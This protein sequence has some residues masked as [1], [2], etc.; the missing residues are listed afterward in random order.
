MIKYCI[1]IPCLFAGLLPA[2][3][4]AGCQSA[5]ASLVFEE[6]SVKAVDLNNARIA[7]P[8]NNPG[9]VSYSVITL[10]SLVMRAYNVRWYQ[11]EGPNH[12]DTGH[13]EIAAKIPEGVP[14]EQTPAMLFNLLAARFNLRTPL[15]IAH[16]NGLFPRGG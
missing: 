3:I 13:Y 10:R 2:G 8:A 5:P 9:R 16:G 14:P 15:R 12:L 6:A 11:I 1:I 4:A 7:R